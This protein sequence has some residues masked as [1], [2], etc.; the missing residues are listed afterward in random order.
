MALALLRSVAVFSCD[1]VHVD[2]NGEL[3]LKMEI[4]DIPKE[5]TQDAIN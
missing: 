5:C 3:K 2:S 4:G 1:V